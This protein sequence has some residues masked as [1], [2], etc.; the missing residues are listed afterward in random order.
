MAT[1][2]LGTGISG[3]AA[4][5]YGLDITGHNIANVSTAGY[6]RQTIETESTVGIAFKSTYLG[7]GTTLSAIERSFNE[8]SFQEVI[9]NKSQYEYNYSSYSNASRIDNLL[10][11]AD[12]GITVS[13]EEMF[14]SINGIAEEPTIISARN[15]LVSNSETVANRFNTLFEEVAVQ[16]LGSINE[17]IETSVDV[18]NSITE[19][20]AFLNNQIQIEQGISD[21]GF[22]PNDLLDKRDLLLT[23]LSE[24]IQVNT[25]ELDDGTLNV[26]VGNGITLVT[27]SVQIPLSV[28]RNEYD[29]TQLEIA[30]S[31]NTDTEVKAIITSQ[32][33]GG[34]LT[35]LFDSRDNVVIPAI[36]E[37]GKLAIAIA[38]NFNRQQSLGLDLNGDAGENIFED[39]NEAQTVLSRTLNSSNNTDESTFEIYIRNTEQLSS[40]EFDMEYDGT[41]LDIFDSNGDLVQ[42][43]TPADIATMSAGTPI[44]VGETGITMAIDTDNLTAGD[45]FKIRPTYYGASAIEGIIE[46]P[47]LVAAA[48]NSL[49]IEEVS[50]LNNVTL[51]LYEIT[52]DST[53]APGPLP[54][55]S[56]SIEID[57]TGTTYQVLDSVGTVISGP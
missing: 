50:N 55:D 8:Y 42:Q 53:T 43:F 54:D 46:E 21:D 12:T 17:E 57:A 14:D 2:I 40:E 33:E 18:I 23:N 26:T 41:N 27:G 19:E 16:Q 3:L 7:N 45:S 31:P 22:E 28:E 1:G 30:I 35:G 4:A 56:I 48:G 51:S 5:Q 20:L 11:D 32:L 44:I 25:I 52:G 10:A 9:Y 6:S 24:L 36:N 13:F 15:V 38:D 34:S 29:N 39:I 37:L 49:Y 47:E